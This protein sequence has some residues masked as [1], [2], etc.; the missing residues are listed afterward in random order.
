VY[1]PQ[2]PKDWRYMQEIMEFAAEKGLPLLLL[3]DTRGADPS[4]NSESGDQSAYIARIIQLTD[5]YPYPV[6][7]VNIGMDG[8]G[9]GETFIHPADAAADFENALSGVSAPEV[10]SWIMTGKWPDEKDLEQLLI[11]QRDAI[12]EGRLITGQIDAIIP[13]GKGGAH[14]DP[15]IPVRY[16]KTWIRDNL[17]ELSRTSTEVLR[18]RRWERGSRINERVTV[19]NLKS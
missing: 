14:R 11:Q 6:L 19:P 3:G 18:E 12:A 4:P 7:S 13:E 17:E 1:L 5:R 8:S 15:R 2:Q 10:Q 16:L 9:G